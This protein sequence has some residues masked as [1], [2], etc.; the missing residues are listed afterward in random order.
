MSSTGLRISVIDNKK[1]DK[2]DSK[3]QKFDNDNSLR[4]SC[5]D[6]LNEYLLN[7]TL[8]G[9]R[10]VGNRT[11]TRIERIFFGCMFFLVI[12]LSIYFISN[13]WSK[14]NQS[15]IIITMNATSTS[16]KDIPFPG[17]ITF[18]LLHKNIHFFE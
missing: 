2:F 12:L 8:H 9:L 13:V 11:I 4:V 7:S 18:I 14:W 5:R 15:P 16:V 10:Y 3:I 6:N 1:K 17:K